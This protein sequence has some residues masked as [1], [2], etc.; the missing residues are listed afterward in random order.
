MDISEHIRSEERGGRVKD[1]LWFEN[2]LAFTSFRT[3]GGTDRANR[4][5]RFVDITS[6]FS[7]FCE[8]TSTFSGFQL[9]CLL[10]DGFDELTEFFKQVPPF[11]MILDSF[12]VELTD[13]I[14]VILFNYFHLLWILFIILLSVKSMKS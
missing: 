6:R 9:W 3:L 10:I 14:H 7:T 8:I 11:R 2:S 13:D 1:T 5:M 4:S 12:F